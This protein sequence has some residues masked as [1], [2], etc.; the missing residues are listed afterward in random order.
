MLSEGNLMEELL[1]FVEAELDAFHVQDH[2]DEPAIQEDD[3]E[4]IMMAGL[5]NS[6]WN[7]DAQQA[8]ADDAD[9]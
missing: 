9:F 1:S 2:E 6:F 4:K 7:S 5:Y 8:A 3:E